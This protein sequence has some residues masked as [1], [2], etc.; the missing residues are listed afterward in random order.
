M[1]GVLV[2]EDFRLEVVVKRILQVVEVFDLDAETGEL[3]FFFRLVLAL[4][5]A[6]YGSL[7]AV[8][9]ALHEVVV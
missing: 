9:E 2:L 1:V 5:A 3:F 7:L 4:L 6:D 8:E